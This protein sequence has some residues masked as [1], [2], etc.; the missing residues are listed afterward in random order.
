MVRMLAGLF[1]QGLLVTPQEGGP[2]QPLPPQEGG[3]GREGAGG[4][5]TLPFN[6]QAQMFEQRVCLKKLI[7]LLR[8][9]GPKGGSRSKATLRPNVCT[10]RLLQRFF[11]I[12]RL[13]R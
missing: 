13:F 3:T 9:S 8:V 12:Q 6:S 2:A 7:T 4:A 11:V 10:A 1:L 5:S